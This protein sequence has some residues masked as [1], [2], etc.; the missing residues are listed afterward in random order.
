[1][2]FFFLVHGIV[3]PGRTPADEPDDERHER[4]EDG[5]EGSGHVGF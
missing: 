2:A 1:M 5:E 4:G 3:A